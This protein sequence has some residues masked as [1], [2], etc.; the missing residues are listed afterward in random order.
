[1]EKKT[2]N[3]SVKSINARSLEYYDM[4]QLS[5][6][7]KGASFEIEQL[8]NGNFHA[9][10]FSATFIKGGLDR[11]CYNRTTF[12]K[13]IFSEEYMTFGFL[14]DAHEESRLNGK[15]F[16]KHD[17]LL[18]NEDMTV[19][20]YLPPDSTWTSFQFKRDDLYK[21]NII[22]PNRESTIY[23]LDKKIK[24]TFARKV[25]KIFTLVEEMC[26]NPD[27]SLN[28][29][30][31]YN[32]LLSLYAR[33][34]DQNAS[35][36]P[37]ERNESLMIARQIY[38]YFHERTAEP[39]QMI[40][41]THLTGKSERTIERIFKNHFGVSPYTYLKLHRLHLIRHKLCDQEKIISDNITQ[42][43]IDSG[44]THMGYFG[45]EYKKLFNEMP[46]ETLKHHI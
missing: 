46:S 9:D 44:F 34:I 8:E 33:S 13:G 18:G 30:L 43:A 22:L 29:E 10:L 27:T 35:N 38:S 26:D 2:E 12:T 37:L 31:I 7:V 42:I 41:L 24:S 5:E 6:V 21:T 23:S 32:Y 25:S 11:G 15:T 4:D 19:D 1:M 36:T 39:I 45:S 17:I 40:H 20:Y 14:L 3:N 28:S 16:Q